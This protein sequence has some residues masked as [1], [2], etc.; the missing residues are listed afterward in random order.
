MKQATP[1]N[2]DWVHA[3]SQLGSCL[4]RAKENADAGR[5]E[6]CRQACRMA[7]MY[8]TDCRD[9]VAWDTAEALS[10]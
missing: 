9:L 3:I 7:E 2:P 8:A 6:R 4:R 5:W 1:F 10:K